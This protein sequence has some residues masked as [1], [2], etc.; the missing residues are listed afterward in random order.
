MSSYVRRKG[1]SPLLS[2][3]TGEKN[4]S[5]YGASMINVII[6]LAVVAV[7]LISAR[8]YLQALRRGGCGCG[9]SGGGE[10][11]VARPQV[12]RHRSAHNVSCRY[13]YFPFFVYLRYTKQKVALFRRGAGDRPPHLI[14]TLYHRDEPSRPGA[15]PVHGPAHADA[16]VITTATPLPA[17][18]RVLAS[19]IRRAVI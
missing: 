12:V 6:V 15:V 17:S 1:A 3:S 10:S 13:S 8:R 19:R 16:R 5:S 9:C 4:A 2:H 14:R 18:S 11:H 7:V